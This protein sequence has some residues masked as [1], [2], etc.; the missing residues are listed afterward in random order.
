MSSKKFSSPNFLPQKAFTLIADII[1]L[2]NYQQTGL[3][4]NHGRVSLAIAL[5]R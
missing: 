2:F 3:N 5:T 4:H 1:S